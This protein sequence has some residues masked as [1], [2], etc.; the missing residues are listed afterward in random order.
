MM[1][2]RFVKLE[3]GKAMFSSPGS[4]A[5]AGSYASR[6]ILL[7]FP[8]LGAFYSLKIPVWEAPDELL[9]FQYAAFVSDNARLPR[10]YDEVLLSSRSPLYYVLLAPVLRAFDRSDLQQTTHP[11]EEYRWADITYGGPLVMRH[12]WVKEEFP[13]GGVVLALHAA[14][15]L[16]VLI[17]MLAVY[18]ALKVGE[19]VFG[20][21]SWS[22]AGVAALCAFLPSFVFMSA[23]VHPDVLATALGTLSLWRALVL[24]RRPTPVNAVLAGS[25]AGLLALTKE[26]GVVFGVVV[27]IAVATLAGRERMRKVLTLAVFSSMAFGVISGPWF[28]TTWFR[29]GDPF[30]W[31]AVVTGPWAKYVLTTAVTPLVIVSQM[32]E[33]WSPQSLFWHTF[34]MAFGHLDIYGP[35]AI[36]I[37]AYGVLAVAMGGLAVAGLRNWTRVKEWCPQTA[38]LG[39]ALGGM[40]LV[41][42]QFGATMATGAHGRY[43][44]PALSVLGVIVIL[45]LRGLLPGRQEKI[46]AVAPMMLLVLAVAAPFTVLGAAYTAEDREGGGNR[47]RESL[48]ASFGSDIG[49]AEALPENL[50]ADPGKTLRLRLTWHAFEDIQ[51]SYRVFV[52]VWDSAG[53]SI[54]RID[55]VPADGRSS[56]QLW[57][58]GDTIFD[59]FELSLPA[60]MAPGQYRVITGF[61]SGSS[62]VRLPV[63][64]ALTGPGDVA[65]VGV[66]KVLEPV[67]VPAGAPIATFGGQMD[68]MSVDLPVT[69][70]LGV[71]AQVTLIWRAADRPTAD[72]TISVQ[73]LAGDG[74]LVAQTDSPPLRGRLPT[75]AWERGD[76]V[77]D[78]MDLALPADAPAELRLQL[79]VY[80][81]T[82][83]RRLRV[84]DGDALDL[85]RVT[86][87]R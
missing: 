51:F 1:A 32:T 69:V 28:L 75:T 33:Q 6:L 85:G 31:G 70:T 59:D 17:G 79:V 76:V 8:L 2:R 49:L 44:F 73:A 40:C 71:A 52:E 16:S 77:R 13:W 82:S 21:G 22:A 18:A 55:R 58:R 53:G 64:G 81:L 54:S 39:A 38:V 9:H 7:I 74:T 62:G 42:A 56:T 72:Y 47:S 63:S 41:A 50:R 34:V 24:I 35:S 11:N 15:L 68:L 37:A 12:D 14:R 4:H 29:Y 43:V 27:F 61:Y 36:Y 3:L 57:R 25:F 86:V 87:G 48:K 78:S 19:E 60:Q 84:G 46:A 66:L 26:S 83:G 30:G 10:S 5:G 67:A 45:G 65:V 20:V 23:I 80:E